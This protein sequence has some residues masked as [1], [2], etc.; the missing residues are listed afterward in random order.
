MS[1]HSSVN[2]LTIVGNCQAPVLAKIIKAC[3][4]PDLEVNSFVLHRDSQ[5]KLDH[6]V[7]HRNSTILAVPFNSV[8]GNTSFSW[9]NLPQRYP[10]S[11]IRMISNAFFEGY[12]PYWGYFYN[13]RGKKIY[14]DWDDYIN[15]FIVSKYLQGRAE[16]L[17]STLILEEMLNRNIYEAIWFR[18]Q[19]ELA[20]RELESASITNISS[21]LDVS[22]VEHD[23]FFWTCN[24]PTRKIFDHMILQI[25]RFLGVEIKSAH[26]LQSLSSYEFL[27]KTKIPTYS[28]LYNNITSNLKDVNYIFKGEAHSWEVVVDMHLDFLA[29]QEIDN[30]KYSL[31]YYVAARPELISV[32]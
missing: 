6:L 21:L 13:S 25:F 22:K 8:K 19:A 27:S 5:D 18:S 32:L 15:Y 2:H 9:R 7:Q 23:Q 29:K 10:S 1:I 30:I 4:I 12:H 16:D 24:H 11:K 28:E 26:T 14:P 20:R 31:Q 17:S 3:S